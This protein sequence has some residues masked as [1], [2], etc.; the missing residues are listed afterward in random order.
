MKK[1]SKLQ[2]ARMISQL[3]FLILLPGLFTLT[4]S[5]I[6]QIYQM[7]YNGNTSLTE[8]MPNLLEVFA[9]FPI[10]IVLGR[11]F[12]GW[13]CAFGT[14]NDIIYLISSKIFKVKYR[15]SEKVDS[16]LKY[17]KYVLLAFIVIA[18][19]STSSKIFEG[20]SPWDAFAQ[21]TDI[22]AALTEYTIGFILL[23]MIIVG[24]AFIERFFCRYLCPLGAMFT[25]TSKLRIF[26]IS[27]PTEKCGKCRICTN[28][29]P[30]GIPLY[31]SEKVTSGE[32]ISCFKCTSVCPRKN[33]QVTVSGEKINSALAASIAIGAFTGIYAINNVVLGS[34]KNNAYSIS[35]SASNKTLQGNYKDGTYTGEGTGFRPG[36]QVQVTIKSNKI[37]NIEILSDNETPNYFSQASSTIPQEIIAAQS[38]QVDAVSGATRS[39]NGIMEAVSNAL[40]SAEGGSSS[41]TSNATTNSNASTNSDSNTTVSTSQ[42]DNSQTADSNSDSSS[43]QSAQQSSTADNNSSESN[44]SNSGT[45]S[46]STAYKDGT[47]TGEGTGFRPGLNVT[48]TVKGGKITGVTVGDNNE[49]PRFSSEPIQVIPEEIVKAQSVN[50]DA[51]S[52]ATR[53]SNGIMEAVTDALSK[54]K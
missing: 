3:A 15:V 6:K 1:I 14:M 19:W 5:G 16:V 12:C 50:V 33:T 25:I 2:I 36:L 35:S 37:T 41:S 18:M 47:Y 30:M 42:S 38:V 45:T 29:C 4:F 53:T 44:Q 54:A 23:L 17:F 22:K 49:T 34:N 31:K 20:A 9:I 28:N 48:V 8:L 7:I 24:A 52:G 32:C 43:S 10:T 40:N 46:N 11:F 27:K 26:K 39:S 51:V 13:M 21:L